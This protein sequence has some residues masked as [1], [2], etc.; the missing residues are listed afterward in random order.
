[1]EE[2]IKRRC[3]IEFVHRG[4][5]MVPIGI[6]QCLL[7]VCGDQTVGVSAVRQWMKCFIGGNSGSHL[8]V[9]IFLSMAYRLSFI[10]GEMHS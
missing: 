9:R 7:N 5:K 1:M 3:G 2:H 4:K 8:L 6:H 10:A